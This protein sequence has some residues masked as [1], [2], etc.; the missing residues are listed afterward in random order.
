MADA[1]GAQV[2]LLYDK[3]GGAASSLKFCM[4]NRLCLVD[5]RH[6]DW[7]GQWLLNIPQQPQV[8]R[9]VIALKEIAATELSVTWRN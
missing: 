7:I 4:N 6:L 9:P 8:N 5:L 1:P 2:T 3:V